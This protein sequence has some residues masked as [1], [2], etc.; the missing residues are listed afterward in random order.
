MTKRLK[1]L[2]R[3]TFLI[4][5][6]LERSRIENKKIILV[7]QI[8]AIIIATSVLSGLLIMM[9]NY[10][11]G[12]PILGF[13]V[14]YLIPFML[15]SKGKIVFAR[16]SMLFFATFSIGVFSY[17]LGFEKGVVFYI[18]PILVAMG[19]T[20]PYKHIKE[21]L[22]QFLFLL[23]V[24]IFLVYDEL[25]KDSTFKPN[26]MF[27]INLIYSYI[28]STLIVLLYS[29]KS[30]KDLEVYSK[31]V[32]F[33]KKAQQIS[34]KSLKEK[35]VLIA[36]IHHRVKNN[37]AVISSMINLQL[38]KDIVPEAKEVL[39]ESAGRISSMSLVHEKLYNQKDLSNVEIKDYIDSLIEELKY[40]YKESVGEVQLD[41]NVD[42]FHVNINQ[43]VPIGLILNELVSNA[44][45]HAFK[46]YNNPKLIITCN[47]VGKNIILSVKDNGNGFD[48]DKIKVK[49]TL[50]I[51]IIES[52]SEQLEGTFEFNSNP[53]K[54]TDFILSFR[55][56]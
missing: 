13:G 6:S 34:S 24:V 28:Y 26:I 23:A 4:G 50:G 33:R 11:V 52:L 16:N 40:T 44:F 30:Q 9:S 42:T 20:F 29:Y 17:I 5:V 3:K 46:N 25:N 38:S 47:Q 22:L 36:E 14:L 55:K 7:N 21:L 37:L 49:P 41:M 53:N 32:T 8:N 45:K 56:Q 39:K 51:T 10:K 12:F 27:W 35:E 19:Y 31:K 15:Q 43:A 48:Y 2:L 54:G 1:K 18:F